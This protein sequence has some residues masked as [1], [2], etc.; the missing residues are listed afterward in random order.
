MGTHDKIE[1]LVLTDGEGK[2][3]AI[4]RET[5]ERYKVSGEQK[6]EIEREL[7]D[8]VQGF[9]MFAAQANA[10]SA[11]NSAAAADVNAAQAN[12][13]F[14]TMDAAAV[15]ATPASA[16]AFADLQSAAAGVSLFGSFMSLS[17]GLLVPGG[18]IGD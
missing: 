16:A 12:A 6:A 1:A 7:G 8:E 4:P 11:A 3:Y 9:S 15:G 5:V 18:P 17:R 10:A 2:L 14:A 13:A